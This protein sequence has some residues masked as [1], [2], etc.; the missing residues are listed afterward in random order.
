L[1]QLKRSGAFACY[2][3]VGGEFD[4]TRI[5][6]LQ[7]HPTRG[8]RHLCHALADAYAQGAPAAGHEVEELS[9]AGLDF[10]ILRSRRD[11]EGVSAGPDIIRAQE[12][13]RAANHLVLVFPLWLGSMPA[14]LKAFLEQTFRPGFA[15]GKSDEGKGFSNELAGRSARIIVTMGMPAPVYRWYFLA[16]GIKSLEQG[17]LK[18]VGT[19]P[20]A[21]PL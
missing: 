17:I 9:V 6:I 10:S 2:E 8:E 7:G 15:T 14:L 19:N 5:A 4:M 20:C 3:L 13:I 12:A 18:L 16:H 1:T 21:G 11:W